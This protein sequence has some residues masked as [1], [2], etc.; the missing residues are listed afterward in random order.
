MVRLLA[1][2]RKPRLVLCTPRTCN[3]AQD[4]AVEW[5]RMT[6]WEARLPQNVT[7]YLTTQR[8]PL[9]SKEGS[10]G[11]SHIINLIHCAQ[12]SKQHRTQH[13]RQKQTFIFFYSFQLVSLVFLRW[14]SIKST[15]LLLQLRTWKHLSFLLCLFFSSS[16]PSHF[17]PGLSLL[18]LCFF[19]SCK[20]LLWKMRQTLGE[21]C[22][23][24]EFLSMCQFSH[25][26]T[27]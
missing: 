22:F 8:V 1:E 4:T 10:E 15:G 12:Q 6:D 24:T 3:T 11:Q 16:S 19:F 26:N 17:P 25:W 5:V 13:S 27:G 20:N 21:A 14:I 9:F 2:I 18:K 7:K 23:P